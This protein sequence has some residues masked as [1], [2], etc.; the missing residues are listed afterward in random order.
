[1][2]W[3]CVI[4]DG[5]KE[6]M[7]EVEEQR[8]TKSRLREM[9]TLSLPGGLTNHFDFVGLDAAFRIYLHFPVAFCFPRCFYPR[10]G[11]SGGG[12]TRT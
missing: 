9:K 5:E 7:E 4:G 1:V 11:T 12:A 6:K 10:L 8:K 3:L 2:W